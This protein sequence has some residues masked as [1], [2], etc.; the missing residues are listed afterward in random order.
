[1][2]QS[3]FENLSHP[4]GDCFNSRAFNHGRNRWAGQP[5]DRFAPPLLSLRVKIDAALDAGSL[6]SEDVASPFKT[7]LQIEG[8]PLGNRYA[9]LAAFAP[10]R[11][12]VCRRMLEVT[13]RKLHALRNDFA[14]RIRL[15]SSIHLKRFLYLSS[16]NRVLLPDALADLSSAG[17]KRPVDRAGQD[18][19]HPAR[20]AR[21]HLTSTVN[22]SAI[23]LDGDLA[24]ARF[25]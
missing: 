13:Q 6:P 20:H 21:K 9:H 14:G 18:F 11:A 25:A 7:T 19:A 10:S 22:G 4:T 23:D 12:F 24:H 5:L 1:M 16:G 15:G 17:R 2:L 8:V 3:L